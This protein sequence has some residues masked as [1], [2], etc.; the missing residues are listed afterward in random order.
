MKD[1]DSMGTSHHQQQPESHQKY[2]RHA[3]PALVV[4]DI[5]ANN[6]VPTTRT[7]L[8]TTKASISK[9]PDIGKGKKRAKSIS[10]L[11]VEVRTCRT[12]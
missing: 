11:N 9:T 8:P 2:E 1:D 5:L 4:S 7:P 6:A 12:S 3:S 10:R